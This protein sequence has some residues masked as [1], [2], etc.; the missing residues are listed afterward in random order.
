MKLV[1]TTSA[2]LSTTLLLA[3]CASPTVVDKHKANDS[4]LSCSQIIQE[5]KEAQTF[6]L[7][8]K[9]TKGVNARNVATAVLFWPAVAGTYYNSKEAIDA[10]E[11]RKDNL[12]ELARTKKCDLGKVQT[13]IE[14]V[15]LE[16]E[17]AKD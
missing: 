13:A 2:V 17:E 8:A 12:T 9:D 7:K 5:A 1:Q 15:T 4:N 10:A 14:S 16:E 6:L 11:E 3:A